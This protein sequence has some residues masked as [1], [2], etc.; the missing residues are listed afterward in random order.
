[1][2]T[3]D[4]CTKFKEAYFEYKA[5][6]NNTWKIT[7]NALFV[8]LDSFAE[9]CHDIMHLTST[10]IQFNKLQKIEIG[11][12]KGKNLTLSILQIFEEF[13]QAVENF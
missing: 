2:T 6:A 1:M 8:R 4:V 11:G 10:I 13:N 3:V 5:Q 12:T 9:R 7:T